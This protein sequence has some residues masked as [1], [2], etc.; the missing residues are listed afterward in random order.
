M[1][2]ISTNPERKLFLLK[3]AHGVSCFG[4]D[5]A[6]NEA[7]Q[8]T[9][10]MHRA[11]ALEER[12]DE[13][14][15][16]VALHMDGKPVGPTPVLYGTLEGYEEYRRAV[17]AYGEHPASK[18]TYFQPGTPKKVARVLEELRDTDTVVRIIQGD[19]ETGK[20]WLDEC[21]VVGYVRRTSG[22]M[23]SLMLVEPLD[24]GYGHVSSA[25]GG[26]IIGAERVLRIIDCDTMRDLYRAANYK[27]PRLTIGSSSER[28][29][30]IG[31]TVGVLDEDG[32]VIAC[33]EDDDGAY[34]HIAFLRG[35]KPRRAY[36][37][38]AEYRADFEGLDA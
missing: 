16:L 5:N 38:R 18:K 20:S 24:D 17:K 37:T 7:L 31:Y 30:A 29:A 25:R 28:A 32:Q 22:T 23:K 2:N 26:S 8:L 10:L 35:D 14:T 3:T 33:F 36:R 34:E 12:V 27:A 11:S 9:R 19:P 21:D 4:F 1:L 6:Y 15:G 13:V